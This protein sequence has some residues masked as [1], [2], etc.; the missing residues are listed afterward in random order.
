MNKK[1][2]KLIQENFFL[3]EISLDEIFSLISEQEA[4]LNKIGFLFEGQ[5]EHS[6]SVQSIPEISISELG[7]SDLSTPENAKEFSS[8]A[9]GQLMN[10][11]KHIQG[12]DLK[13]KIDSLNDFYSMDEALIEKLN[14]SDK[15]AGGRVS[16]VLSY[17]VFYKTLTTIITNFNASS[18]GFTFESFLAVLLGG[19]QI[20]T[21]EGTIA[22][23]E[24]ADGTKISLK[25]YGEASVQAGGSYRDLVQDMITEPHQMQYVVCTKMLKTQKKIDPETKA[26]T[27]EKIKGDIASI[28]FY[29]YT[30]TLG[31]IF[32]ILA[33]SSI[34]SRRNIILPAAYIADKTDVASTLPVGAQYPDPSQAHSDFKEEAKT[35]IEAL[36]PPILSSLGA[37]D[38]E[39]LWAALD[40][41]NIES[42]IWQRPKNDPTVVHGKSLVVKRNVANKLRRATEAGS[43]VF[44]ADADKGAVGHLAGAVFEANEAIR[45]KY[46]LKKAH[47]ARRLAVSAAYFPKVDGK[48]PSDDQLVAASAAAYE[49]LSDEDKIKALTQSLGYTG[50]SS[51]QAGHFNMTGHMVKNIHKVDATAVSGGSIEPEL[52]GAIEAAG[53]KTSFVGEIHVGTDAIQKM[54][55]QCIK[56][57]N[58]DIF[59]IFDNLKTLTTNIKTYFA[60]GL[61]A[62]DDDYARV[63]ITAADNIE[64]KTSEISGVEVD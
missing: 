32:K 41:S 37:I 62:E 63:A 3:D 29:R 21:G 18:A 28:Q 52:E 2:L 13:G 34:E 43:N 17:L 39:K 61:K 12:P 15:A 19:K 49:E 25:L 57:I 22:D 38:Y 60:G 27:I 7:W 1:E 16:S 4:K 9:R 50:G 14:L 45:S 36:D 51:A 47:D 48:S 11:L 20:S 30:F 58:Q 10:F 6:F 42:E 59:R 44:S 35:R 55:D 5:E 24:T 26:E 33:K 46:G 56:L 31:N 53:E 8:T 64:S 23:L 40:Y 54:L